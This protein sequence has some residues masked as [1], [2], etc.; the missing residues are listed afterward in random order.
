MIHQ[1][2]SCSSQDIG[3]G[4]LSD[5]CLC[6][7]V[8]ITS[9]R[10][11]S[12]SELSHFPTLPVTICFLSWMSSVVSH[13]FG[14]GENDKSCL[15][16]KWFSAAKSC[17]WVISRY[18]LVK[19]SLCSGCVVKS[20]GGSHNRCCNYPRWCQGPTKPGALLHKESWRL[21]QSHSIFSSAV[22][23]GIVQNVFVYE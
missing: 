8:M 23:I 22:T 12:F 3:S 7:I 11:F 14:E 15:N 9:P 13:L 21:W 5:R 19:N 16:M 2:P 18:L 17:W 1:D 20:W 6:S 4:K 10:V